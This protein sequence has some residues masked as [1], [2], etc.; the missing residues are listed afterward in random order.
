M[1]RKNKSVPEPDQP[2]KK[3]SLWDNRLFLLVASLLCAI[4]AWSIVTLTF[5]SE[6]AR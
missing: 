6:G 3:R 4:I 2:V 1:N 5:D